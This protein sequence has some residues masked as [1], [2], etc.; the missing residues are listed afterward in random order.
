MVAEPCL[1][2]REG[3]AVGNQR[4]GRGAAMQGNLLDHAEESV[5]VPSAVA[6]AVAPPVSAFSAELGPL[7]VLALPCAA[8]GADA[9]GPAVVGDHF[10]SSV[11]MRM[12]RPHPA[13]RLGLIASKHGATRTQSTWNP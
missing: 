10:M 1:A 9:V 5:A 4:V 12:C 11:V 7:S 8:A 13:S 6:D 2:V 3:S